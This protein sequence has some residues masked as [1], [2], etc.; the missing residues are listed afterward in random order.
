MRPQVIHYLGGNV[1]G[2][3]WTKFSENPGANTDEVLYINSTTA[4][5]ETT[6]YSAS[7]DIEADLMYTEPSIKLVYDIAANRKIG[8]DAVIEHIKVDA[9]SGDAWKDTVA[10]AISSIDGEKKMSMSGTLNVRGDSVHG[11]YDADTNTFT[12]T[13]EE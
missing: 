10:V 9:F 11:T 13:E 4:S 1:C 3:G 6:D 5:S 8:E 12:P 2:G 7:Y